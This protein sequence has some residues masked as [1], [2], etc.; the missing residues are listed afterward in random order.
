MFAQKENETRQK[1]SQKHDTPRAIPTD[2]K[3]ETPRVQI[4]Q[5]G[6]NKQREGRSTIHKQDVF[7]NRKTVM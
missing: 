2:R 1:G 6:L 7:P 3:E 4:V 5:Y